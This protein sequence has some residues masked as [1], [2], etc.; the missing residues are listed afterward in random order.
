MRVEMTGTS[1]TAVRRSPFPKG[2][3]TG[4][5]LR[6]V[7]EVRAVCRHIERHTRVKG[8]DE[9]ICDASLTR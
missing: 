1:S 7:R 3:G 5:R 9:Y 2:E 8:A 4:R 6:R